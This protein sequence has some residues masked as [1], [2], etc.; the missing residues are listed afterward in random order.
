VIDAGYPLVGRVHDELINERLEG[1]G[2]LDEY[3]ELMCPDLDWLQGVPIVAEGWTGFRY[4]K[5]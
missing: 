4:R 1:E 3:L 2:D 5:T